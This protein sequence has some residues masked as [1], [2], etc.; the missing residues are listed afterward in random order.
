MLGS[1]RLGWPMEDQVKDD[2]S[3]LPRIYCKKHVTTGKYSDD[4]CYSYVSEGI[5][6][7]TA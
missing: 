6:S 1:N 3:N 5:P 2:I 7:V 4:E